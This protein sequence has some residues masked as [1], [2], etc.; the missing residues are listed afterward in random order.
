MVLCFIYFYLFLTIYTVINAI[1]QQRSVEQ[2][3]AQDSVPAKYNFTLNNECWATSSAGLCSCD[4]KT[5][6]STT[7]VEQQVAQDSV[8]AKYNLTLNNEVLSNK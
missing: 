6:N 7:S 1:T 3:V 8:P 2:Q 5:K 4:N